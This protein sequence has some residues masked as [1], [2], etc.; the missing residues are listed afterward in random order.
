MSRSKKSLAK[1]VKVSRSTES[2][3]PKS[4]SLIDPGLDAK[5]VP[6]PAAPCDAKPTS[7]I[8]VMLEAMLAEVRLLPPGSDVEEFME[9][10]LPGIVRKVRE[11]MAQARADDQA[12]APSGA[13][14]SPSGMSQVR[15]CDASGQET[16]PPPDDDVGPHR[17]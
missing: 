2:S 10:H 6:E 11:T 17:V 15:L 1:V 8:E 5:S 12:A 9:E 4:A 14:F 16:K 7:R 3:T 13:D